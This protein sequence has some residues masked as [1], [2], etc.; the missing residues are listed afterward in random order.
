M[1]L[2][3]S[4]RTIQLPP[5]RLLSPQSLIL[6]NCKDT[7]DT[8]WADTAGIMVKLGG[9]QFGYTWKWKRSPNASFLLHVDSVL[10]P[11]LYG[12]WCPH[13]QE[14]H[15]TWQRTQKPSRKVMSYSLCGWRN[16]GTV[17]LNGLPEALAGEAGLRRSPTLPPLVSH[18]SVWCRN[19]D[20]TKDTSSLPP[21]L[22]CI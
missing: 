11:S 6:S 1:L 16:G 20:H 22:S 13:F 19:Q 10:G 15:R 5:Q 17:Q 8:S 18:L 14:T 9:I 12:Q 2:N 3:F 21:F 7:H 4:Q